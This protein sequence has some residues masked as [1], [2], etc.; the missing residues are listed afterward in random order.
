MDTSHYKKNEKLLMTSVDNQI[1]H[2]VVPYFS[3]IFS[4]KQRSVVKKSEIGEE[5]GA[6]YLL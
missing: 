3:S 2:A 6:A 1:S 5:K 4:E